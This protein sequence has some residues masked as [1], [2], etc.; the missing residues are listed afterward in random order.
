MEAYFEERDMIESQIRSNLL[1]PG[2]FKNLISY[3]NEEEEYVC[4]NPKNTYK[5]AVLHPIEQTP[6]SDLS[7]DISMAEDDEAENNV[8]DDE[9]TTLE[10]KSEEEEDI[11]N[12]SFIL[13]YCGLVF[14]THADVESIRVDFSYA[15]YQKVG[16]E[17]RNNISIKLGNYYEDVVNYVNALDGNETQNELLQK[18]NENDVKLSYY[19][20]FNTEE[21][22]LS[23][24]NWDSKLSSLRL[25]KLQGR[26]NSAY[27]LLRSLFLDFYKRN[28]IRVTKELQLSEEEI[29]LNEDVKCHLQK[30]EENGKKYVKILVQNTH[31]NGGV[32]HCLFQSELKVSAPLQSYTDSMS[33]NDDEENDIIQF[34]YRDVE[35]FGKGV[36][37]AADWNDDRTEIWTSFIPM[38]DIPKFS[39]SIM[40]ES[41]NECCT[42]RNLSH[43]HN[44]DENL[45]NQLSD[46]VH[47]Y[48]TWIQE[49]RRNC[50]DYNNNSIAQ[51]IVDKQ[52]A[53]LERLQDNIQ[54]LRE[55]ERALRCFRMANTAMLIQ[56]VISRH[57]YFKKCREDVETTISNMEFFQQSGYVSESFSEPRYCPFQL[58]FLLM[59]VKSTFE[60]EDRYRKDVDLIWFPTGGGKTEAYLALT[61]L[62]ILERRTNPNISDDEKNGVSVIMRYTLRLLT[63]QQFER[64]S[65]LIVSLQ[66]LKRSGLIPGSDITIGL[67][68][69]DCINQQ[70]YRSRGIQGFLDGQI[71]SNPFPV[72]YCPWCGQKIYR[73]PGSHGY[74]EDLSLQCI[75]HNC[76]YHNGLPIN[77]SDERI[78]GNPP[79]LLFATVDKFANIHTNRAVNMLIGNRTPDLIIQDELHLISGPLGSTVGFFEYIV[80]RLSEIKG[81]RTKIVASTATTRNTEDLVKCLYNRKLNVFPAQGLSYDD[82]YFSYVEKDGKPMRRHIGILPYGIKSVTIEIR[83]AALLVV[84]RLCLLDKYLQ[85]EHVDVND[86]HAVFDAVT[87][88]GKLIGI[89]DSYWSIVFFFNSLKDVGRSTSRISHEF[90][91]CVRSL[92]LTNRYSDVLDYVIHGFDQRRCEFSSRSVT[93]IKE[94]LVAAESPTSLEITND[95]ISVD[96]SLDIVFATNMISVGIDISRWNLMLMVG[97]P[98]ST[99]EYIQTSSRIARKSPGLVVN[100]LNSYR[101]RESSLFENYKTFHQAYY[102]FVEPLSSTPLTEAMID[103]NVLKNIIKAY[104]DHICQGASQDDIVNHLTQELSERFNLDDLTKEY[105]RG[106]ILEEYENAKES[107]GLAI[108]LR[109][110]NP[111][112]HIKIDDLYY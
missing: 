26:S 23:V 31:E 61:A 56:M 4:G 98:R 48:D 59:N 95:K 75:N 88:D 50:V 6:D 52:N 42:L 77:Y 71:Q 19:L 7:E 70:R 83:I 85:E 8:A 13:N 28:F 53:L 27:S 46:F 97:Q 20:S 90:Y 74:L 17:N 21:K 38:C 32:G 58:A 47:R 112:C 11:S 65:N 92:K 33:I 43:F 105:L 93:P 22:T 101:C 37:C 111:N 2:A 16:D 87:N 99:A 40:D 91:E 106:K 66:F 55:N 64:A 104:S 35:N 45:M 109:Y 34:I 107:R 94:L 73:N 36:H 103:Q 10:S 80:E 9:E 86:A 25:V 30:Y 63:A 69:G 14:C 72:S 24:K 18:I 12:D 110:V 60:E 96:A 81:H 78:Y 108:T 39:N 1:G 15:K 29:E 62:T 5:I 102:R 89:L 76:A 84:S 54:Y 67:W 100:L 41:I 49:K 3:G 82:N 51:N 44:D 68:M 57:P 79:T